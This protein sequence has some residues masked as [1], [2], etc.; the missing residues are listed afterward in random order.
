MRVVL[1]RIGIDSGAGEM[2]GP[3][4]EDGSF[5]LV[6]IPDGFHKLGE[7]RETY[8]N[9]KCRSGRFLV[10]YFPEGMR[11]NYKNSP[12]HSDPEF[13]TFTYGDPTKGAKRGLRN[14]DEGDL[15]VFYA[16]LE[17]WPQRGERN[18]YIVG[19]FNV[20]WAGLAT[21]LSETELNARFHNNF[22]VKHKDALQDQRNRLVLVQ[23]DQS[24][25]LLKKAVPI[26]AM[27]KDKAG[28]PLK[29]LSEDAQTCFSDFG[30]RIGIQR[31]AP[32]WVP[33]SHV[34]NA[35]RFVRS[36]A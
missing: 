16:G 19:Y 3:L 30:G 8:G 21:E 31:S 20:C 9:T 6:P 24:S 13:E 33:A 26:S 14:L 7:N 1:L 25:K 10:D 18:L 15:L 5:E 12:I 4:F 34:A 36:L 27:G 2:Q 35:A 32:R 23:G 17:P 29:V 11:A 28:K 22:H